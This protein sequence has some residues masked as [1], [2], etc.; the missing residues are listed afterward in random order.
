[1]EHLHGPPG[2]EC[3]TIALTQIESARPAAHALNCRLTGNLQEESPGINTANCFGYKGPP[4]TFHT[5]FDVVL[6]SRK[7][8]FLGE[9]RA[10]QVGESF[11]RVT[12]SGAFDGYQSVGRWKKFV[13]IALPLH[14]LISFTLNFQIDSAFDLVLFPLNINKNAQPLGM[15]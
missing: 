5:V 1:M 13:D 12:P 15:L 3:V 2:A 4:S 7:S 10:T 6:Q 11:P 9:P 14:E 8:G